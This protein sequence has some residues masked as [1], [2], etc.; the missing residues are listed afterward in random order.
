MT[1]ALRLALLLVLCLSVSGLGGWVTIPNIPVWYHGLNRPS[2]APPD[3]VFGP[4]W[5]TLYIMMAVAAWRAWSRRALAAFAVQ[6]TLNLIW[7][8]VFFGAHWIGA[9]VIEILALWVAILVTAREF[10]LRDRL[11][12][13]LMVPYIAWVSFATYLDISFWRLN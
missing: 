9:S 10:W 3:W 4:V 7:S 12:G 8:F 11:A 6:L 2:L 13:M 1:S 5:T